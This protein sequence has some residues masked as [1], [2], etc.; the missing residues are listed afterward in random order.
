M[1][2]RKKHNTNTTYA[3]AK[4][5]FKYENQPDPIPP[6][7]PPPLLP[8]PQQKKMKRGPLSKAFSILTFLPHCCHTQIDQ[9]Y[10]Q[11]HAYF[12]LATN[13]IFTFD[14]YRQNRRRLSALENK[15]IKHETKQNEILEFFFQKKRKNPLSP[16]KQ[17]SSP[18]PPNSTSC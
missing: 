16:E 13:G 7:L 2:I 9:I 18:I 1:T 5:A 17:P 15:K 14:E 11:L 8:R 6:P 4:F 3:T 12:S 10:A